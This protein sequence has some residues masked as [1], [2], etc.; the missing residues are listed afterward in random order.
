MQDDNFQLPPQNT[1]EHLP[2]SLQ[3]DKNGNKAIIRPV[4]NLEPLLVQKLPVW[5]RTMDITGALSG[6]IFLLPLFAI[7][8]LMIKIVSPGPVFFKQKRVGHGGR[9]FTFLKFRTMHVNADGRFHSEYV[10]SLIKDN[11][12]N[13]AG[14]PMAKLDNNPQIIQLGKFLR[15]TCIDEFPQ[16]I[17]VLRGEMSLVGPRPDLPYEIEEY[18]DWNMKRHNIVPGMTGLWQVSGKNRLTFKEMIRLDIT[19][20]KK[21]S[22][23]LDIKILLFTIPAILLQIIDFYKDKKFKT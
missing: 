19:Y 10:K 4:M 22:F 1:D 2:D 3:M 20:S 11:Q 9:I 17:N 21:C 8:A 18:L 13:E 23:L 14:K 15:K 16:L 5:K 7:V 12:N 6:L